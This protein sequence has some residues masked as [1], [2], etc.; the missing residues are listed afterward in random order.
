M[1]FAPACARGDTGKVP[2]LATPAA[3]AAEAAA[4][5]AAEAAAK[6]EGEELNRRRQQP[7]E[8]SWPRPARDS[9]TKPRA[10]HPGPTNYWL[11]A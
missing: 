9:C 3:V 2:D 6:Q 10:S 5:A 11:V 7:S 1:Q 4:A 8:R